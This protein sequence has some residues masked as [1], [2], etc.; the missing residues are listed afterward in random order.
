MRKIFII[1]YGLVGLAGAAY[2]GD[3]GRMPEGPS[4]SGQ[5]KEG[6]RTSLRNYAW[7]TEP[8]K[9]QRALRDQV[10]APYERFQS[11]YNDLSKDPRSEYFTDLNNRIPVLPP[12]KDKKERDSEKWSIKE[13]I[14]TFVKNF[15]E[16]EEVGEKIRKVIGDKR[17]KK[18]LSSDEAYEGESDPVFKAFGSNITPEELSKVWT[19]IK[20]QHQEA[21]LI[22]DQ[23][24]LQEAAIYGGWIL[25]LGLSLLPAVRKKAERWAD[26][27][28]QKLK[29]KGFAANDWR[30]EGARSLTLVIPFVGLQLL[31]A[32]VGMVAGREFGRWLYWNDTDK[33]LLGRETY[34]K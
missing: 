33:E 3:N 21:F 6:W 4:T 8:L 29:D 32:T 25:G 18:L 13:H 27:V 30:V 31:G 26:Q 10:T 15:R 23:Q 24:R 28:A 11:F 19:Y 12:S 9:E 20:D 16:D 14:T 2:A 7:A 17:Y 22:R 1:L 5:P 34:W